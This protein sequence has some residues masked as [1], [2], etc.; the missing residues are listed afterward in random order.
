MSRASG[1]AYNGCMVTSRIYLDNAATSWP[2]PEA[3]YRAADH[4]LREIGGPNGRSGYREAL[5]ANRIVERARRGVAALIG[6]RE[7]SHVVFGFNGTDELN[8]A[9]R[10]TVRPGDHVVVPSG[11]PHSFRNVGTETARMLVIGEPG[12]EAFFYDVGLGAPEG[13]P[14]EA[15]I[16]R[17]IQI[18]QK[19]GQAVLGPHPGH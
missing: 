9:I 11:T 13:P 15:Q 1:P 19:H 10:G 7:P 3:V 8:L 6:A 12:L 17:T 16:R 14:T 18:M 4:Y 5:E 2:K